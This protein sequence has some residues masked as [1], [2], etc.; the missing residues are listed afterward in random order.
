VNNTHNPMIEGTITSADCAPA[1]KIGSMRPID[2]SPSN[3]IV[4]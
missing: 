1:M 2:R 4:N 3:D